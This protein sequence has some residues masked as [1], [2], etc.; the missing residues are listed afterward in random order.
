MGPLPR[1]CA[2]SARGL[3][4]GT[5]H[6]QE[7]RRTPAKRRGGLGEE[8]RGHCELWRVLGSLVPFLSGEGFYFC[9]VKLL[10]IDEVLEQ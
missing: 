10:P 6:A 1:D 5:S 9:S 3:R 4:L 2:G 7:E 8:G